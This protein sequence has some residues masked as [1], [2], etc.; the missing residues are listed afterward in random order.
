M[1]TFPK[2]PT[3]KPSFPISLPKPAHVGEGSC[4]SRTRS[5][6]WVKLRTKF[7][8]WLWAVYLI[9]MRFRRLLRNTIY[10]Q[11]VRPT[12]SREGTGFG[13]MAPYVSCWDTN[14][15]SRVTQRSARVPRVRNGPARPGQGHLRYATGHLVIGRV[16]LASLGHREHEVLSFPGGNRPKPTIRATFK[17]IVALYMLTLYHVS[18]VRFFDFHTMCIT[19][20]SISLGGT[21]SRWVGE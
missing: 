21:P 3:S 17:F 11:T 12:S 15:N 10:I 1:F 19:S 5:L 2:P 14:V 4:E 13:I 9:F 16:P 8:Q 7:F 6:N 18:A 20:D